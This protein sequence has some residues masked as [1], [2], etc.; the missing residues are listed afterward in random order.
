[1][2]LS[3]F[4]MSLINDE[5]GWM[6]LRIIEASDRPSVYMRPS[7]ITRENDPADEVFAV[8][9]EAVTVANFKVTNDGDDGDADGIDDVA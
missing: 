5:N 4:T 6:A 7:L 9:T 8:I 3:V 1:M 2:K